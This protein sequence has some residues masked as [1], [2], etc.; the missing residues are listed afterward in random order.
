MRFSIWLLLAV[1]MR[2]R[3]TAAAR[4]RKKRYASK[5]GSHQK[6]WARG[7][8]AWPNSENWDTVA[9]AKRGKTGRKRT[10]PDTT[11]ALHQCST[12]A[13]R[14]KQAGQTGQTVR[15]NVEKADKPYHRVTLFRSVTPRTGWESRRVRYDGFVPRV[16]FIVFVL[17][18]GSFGCG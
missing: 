18:A 15:P 4:A 13:A 3:M 1:P 9:L 5:F 16:S 14:G 8:G 6:S 10:K 12:S 7:P 11:T 2:M 17:Q